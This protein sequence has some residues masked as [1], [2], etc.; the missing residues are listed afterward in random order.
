MSDNE[1]KINPEE[2]DEGLGEESESD[3]MSAEE[4]M[5][6]ALDAILTGGLPLRMIK[7]EDDPLVRP[8]I[9]RVQRQNEILTDIST[10][11]R[12]IAVKMG[13]M[14]FTETHVATADLSKK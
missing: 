12:S 4:F 14:P 11:I 13:A 6:E 1:N 3:E 7:S 9:T 8:L 2:L 10:S 5:A